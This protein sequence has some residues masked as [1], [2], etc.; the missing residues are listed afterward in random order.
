M[1]R[2]PCETPP[3]EGAQFAQTVLGVDETAGRFADVTLLRC[4]QC[5]ALWLHYSWEVEGISRSGRW[6]RGRVKDP[7]GATLTP[8][9][10]ARVLESLPDY[11]CGGSYFQGKI[12]VARGKL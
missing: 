6:Y 8:T 12:H 10:A 4:Q 9:D 7:V 3:F 5:Q 1:M 11:F 2:C